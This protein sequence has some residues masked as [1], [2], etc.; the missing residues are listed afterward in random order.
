MTLLRNCRIYSSEEGKR[1]KFPDDAFLL[2]LR[3]VFSLP[4][5]E[6]LEELGEFSKLKDEGMPILNCDSLLF[7][8]F[9]K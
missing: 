9:I 6:D 2:A 4:V 3:H 1:G 7:V 8:I 5:L